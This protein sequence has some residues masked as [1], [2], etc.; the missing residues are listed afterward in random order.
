ML[1]FLASVLGTAFLIVGRHWHIGLTGDTADES[2]HKV[3]VGTVPRV[4]GV[5]VYAAG[6][7]GLALI[8]RGLPDLIAKIVWMMWGCLT[9]IFVSGLVEDL[10][11]AVAPWI[12][13]VTALCAAVL[14]SLAH[15]GYGISSVGIDPLDLTLSSSIVR[16]GFFAFAVA[17]LAHGFNLIDGRNGLCA[18]ASILIFVALGITASRTEQVP[19]ANLSYIM[20]AA[21]LGFLLFNFPYGKIFLGDGGAYFNGALA[22]VIT[23]FVV[24]GSGAASPWLAVLILI[25]PVWETLFT[26]GRRVY[27]GRSFYLPDNDHLHHRLQLPAPEPGPGQASFSALPILLLTAPFTLAAPFFADQTAVLIASMLAFVVIYL[28]LYYRLRSTLAEPVGELRVGMQK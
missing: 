14:F 28:L 23:V 26:I 2:H 17:S 19:L 18:G 4:G 9:I 15:D 1:V 24:Q 11:R 10:T 27:A 13:Y 7:V 3:H 25:Y 22:A 16:V 5:A 6:L 12:R 8:S 21:N 20:A